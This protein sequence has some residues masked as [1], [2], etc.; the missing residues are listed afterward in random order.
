MA[1]EVVELRACVKNGGCVVHS[2]LCEADGL[3][4][5]DLASY[6]VVVRESKTGQ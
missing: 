2:G 6:R 5:S 1:G 3:T 4:L